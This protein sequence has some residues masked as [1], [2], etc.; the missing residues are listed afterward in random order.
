MMSP[1]TESCLKGGTIYE[2]KHVFM[3]NNVLTVH[4]KGE[5]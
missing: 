2:D 5:E 1:K 3:K 4:N